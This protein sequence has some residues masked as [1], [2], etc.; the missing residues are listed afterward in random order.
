MAM[1]KGEKS[2]MNSDAMA[3]RG[4]DPASTTNGKPGKGLTSGTHE[5]IMNAHNSKMRSDPAARYNATA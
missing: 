4:K 2:G 5:S 1:E 3:P